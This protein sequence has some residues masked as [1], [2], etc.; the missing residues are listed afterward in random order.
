MKGIILAG[1]MGTRL[2]PSSLVINKH[3]IPVYDKPMIY[4]PLSTLMLAEIRD[5]LIISTPQHLSLFQNLLGNGHQWGLDFSYA[6]QPKA[7]GIPQ[8]F[9]IGKDFIGN[10]PICLILGDNIFQGAGLEERL[11]NAKKNFNGAT[12]FAYYVESPQRYGIVELDKNSKAINIIEKPLNPK[13]NYAVTGI[14][15]YDNQVIEAANAIQPSKRGELE[16]SDVNTWYMQKQQLQV[17]ILGRGF[18][19]FDM[20]THQSLL[21]ASN[22]VEVIES[23]QGLKIGCP[24]EI[25]W[26]KKYISDQQFEMLIHSTKNNEYGEYLIKLLRNKEI[27]ELCTI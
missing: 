7:A 10:D 14:Y 11:K 5:I 12:V 2:Y 19:W 21:H 27:N 8:A 17:E 1:G 4:Y 24:E 16:I 25:A 20:G 3:L 9:T 26:R 18:S 23:R 13:S 6:E 15:F 22:Y